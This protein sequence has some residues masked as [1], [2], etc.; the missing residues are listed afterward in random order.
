MKSN[1]IEALGLMLK[2]TIDTQVIDHALLLLSATHLRSLQASIACVLE[3]DAEIGK[4]RRC[5]VSYGPAEHLLAI[6]AGMTRSEH[7]GCEQS[8]QQRAEM[9][10]S[11]KA[12]Q[13]AQSAQSG[14]VADC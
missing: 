11:V 13:S 8:R 1:Q 10:A 6:N 5:S 7:D 9:Q 2:S 4:H 3:V 12:S 14:E